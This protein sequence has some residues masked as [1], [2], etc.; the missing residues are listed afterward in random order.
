L[1]FPLVYYYYYFLFFSQVPLFKN[2]VSFE[3]CPNLDLS[4]LVSDRS[5]LEPELSESLSVRGEQRARTFLAGPP[6][7]CATRT[8][9]STQLFTS[10]HSNMDWQP[11][12]EPLRQLASC[13]KD[14]LNGQDQSVRK[15]AEEVSQFSFSFLFSAPTHNP[16]ALSRPSCKEYRQLD[17]PE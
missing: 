17:R 5:E 1:T 11:Q 4:P 12:D 7:L 14:S 8:F 15:Q 16:P 13:L 3:C 6:P 10:T 9:A 2:L